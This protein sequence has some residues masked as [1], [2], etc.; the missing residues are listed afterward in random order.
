MKNTP[1]HQNVHLQKLRNIFGQ[2]PGLL[3]ESAPLLP[4]FNSTPTLYLNYLRS[5]A[6]WF[7]ALPLGCECVVQCAERPALLALLQFVSKYPAMGTSPLPLE[8]HGTEGLAKMRRSWFGLFQAAAK[9][10]RRRQ[11]YL[12]PNALQL[13]IQFNFLENVWPM[14]YQ[15][16]KTC[17]LAGLRRVGAGREF[18]STTVCGRK[19]NCYASDCSSRECYSL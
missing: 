2:I 14:G 17:H 7:C 11:F 4:S 6:V 5:F 1:C 10:R 8:C 16:A 9:G 15:R 3:W 19:E 12:P 18:Q 13:Y